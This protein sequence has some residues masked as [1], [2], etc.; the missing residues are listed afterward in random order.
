[1]I[2]GS[3]SFIRFIRR[4]TAVAVTA[5]C[6]P[7]AEAQQKDEFNYDE[8][9]VPSF[10]LPELLKTADGVS[11]TSAE[12]WMT[13]RRPEVLALFEQHVFGKLPPN[14]PKLRTRLRSSVADAVGGKALR[15]EITVFFSD[16]DNGPSMDLMIYTPKDA[17]GPVPC[18]L[19]LNF[20]GNHSI[21]ADPRIHLSE[22]WMREDQKRGNINHQATEQT[23]GSASSRWP[24]D[25]IISRGYGLAT[26]YYGDIDPD[27]DDGFQNG[28][29][30]LP[31]LEP[32]SDGERPADAGGSISA[33][34]WG[35]S[36]AMDI[37]EQDPHVNAEQIALLGHSRLGKTSLWA[38]ACD[39][40]FALVISNNSGCGGAALSRR[41]F[42][43]TVKRINTSFP[44]WFCR[45]HRQYNDNE[46]ALPVDHHM[47]IA[48]IAPRPVYVASAEED[49]WAD[50]R[51]EMLSLYY[52]G[53][54]YAL[55]GRQGLPSDMLPPLNQP[56]QTDVG[57]HIRTGK[58]DVTDFDWTQYLNFADAR[59]GNSGTSPEDGN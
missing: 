6:L 1:M 36:R 57:Y 58:H 22:S 8:A 24:L 7:M 25:M 37:L 48:L 41:R 45:N 14:V 55:F 56:V 44:H 52:A 35:L 59:L 32:K 26:I 16:D 28:I 11:V 50:P 3:P 29:H 9:K 47:L 53:P 33:W 49:R 21:E 13:Q 40:R 34:S 23:R 19:G 42:G 18:F 39:Q 5:I 2:H 51:G 30:A 15:R 12:Q 31:E 4:L 38:G 27:F 10:E 43:E 20:N 17:A 46:N 54:V